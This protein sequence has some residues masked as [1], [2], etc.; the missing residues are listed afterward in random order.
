MQFLFLANALFWASDDNLDLKCPANFGE[1][2]VF[3]AGS[4]KKAKCCRALKVA[5]I[6]SDPNNYSI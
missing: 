5:K 1:K 2:V 4:Q 6:K 3:G